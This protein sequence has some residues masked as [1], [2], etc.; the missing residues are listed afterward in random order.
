[1]SEN[2]VL[3]QETGEVLSEIVKPFQADLNQKQRLASFV[4]QC[5]HQVAKIKK[6]K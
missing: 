1:M 2:E 5:I 6:H 4:K 3:L